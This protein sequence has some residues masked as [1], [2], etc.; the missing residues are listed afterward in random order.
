[1]RDGA[2]SPQQEGRDMRRD[3]IPRDGITAGV[4]G[5]TSVAVWFFLVDI[6]TREAFHTPLNLGRGLL[7]VLGK[8]YVD[9]P[10]TIVVAYTIFHYVAFIAAGLLAAVIVHVSERTPSVLAGAFIFFVMMEIGIIGWSSILAQS[11]FFGTLSW[12]Q[13]AVGNLIAAL[14]MSTYLWRTHP[15]LKEKLDVALG[16]R[17]S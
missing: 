12:I 15:T 5:A 16:A 2:L 11:P 10:V 8:G 6:A 1:V 17:E 13:V 7:S 14:I 9:S 3:T 4:L